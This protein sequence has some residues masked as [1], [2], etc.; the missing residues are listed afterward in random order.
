[1]ITQGILD[2]FSLWLAGLVGL[3][4]PMPAVWAQML[5]D[6]TAGG[7]WLS[8]II[9]TTGPIVPWDAFAGA[10]AVWLGLMAFWAVMLGIRFVLWIVAR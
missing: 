1:M 3:M 2:F 5:G 8:G 4:P 7:G 10:V 9:S 6:L